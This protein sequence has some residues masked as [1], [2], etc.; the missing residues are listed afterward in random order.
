MHGICEFYLRRDLQRQRRR[1]LGGMST[2]RIRTRALAPRGGAS[3]RQ[4]LSPFRATLFG[5]SETSN[6]LVVWHRDT[7]LPVRERND[8][9]GGPWSTK[10]KEGVLY[11]HEPASSLSKIV[12]LRV[13]FDDSGERKGPLRVLP[14]THKLGVLTDEQ[15]EDVSPRI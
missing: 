13:P 6:R 8:V 15:T 3:C 7:A 9:R 11:A 4:L 10:T 5:K 2:V 1:C 12:A 14:S